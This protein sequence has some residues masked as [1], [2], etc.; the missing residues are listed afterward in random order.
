MLGIGFLVAAAFVA[1]VGLSR[2]F[3]SLEPRAEA[4][5]PFERALSVGLLSISAWVASNWALALTSNLTAGGLVVSGVAMAGIGSV[6]VA[7]FRTS[8]TD[9]RSNED[10]PGRR[11]GGPAAAAVLGLALAP[12]VLWLLY[13]LWR[14]WILPVLSEDGL[15][16]HL[17]KAV[18]LM[19]AKGFQF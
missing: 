4:P 11:E 5:G 18:N 3:W 19:R 15:I 6:L 17:P 9:V 14:G 13:I 8:P 12:V 2:L 16:Y 1:G 10:S 7:R